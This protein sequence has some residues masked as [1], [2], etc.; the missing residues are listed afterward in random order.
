M[1]FEHTPPRRVRTRLYLVVNNYDMGKLSPHLHSLKVGSSVNIR[2]PVGR[3]K[4]EKNA[5]RRIGL[6]A[7]GSG[8]TPCLQLIRCLLQGPDMQDDHT[9]LVLLFQ[10]R[11]EEDILLREELDAL[12][13]SHSS[14]LQVVYFL[15][16]AQSHDFGA[17]HTKH[18]EKR[19]YINQA[20]VQSMLAPE[21]CQLVCICGPS[22]FN[23]S[24][25][26]LLLEAGHDEQKSIYVW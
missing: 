16:N 22:G 3:F 24:V 5:Y 18:A 14:R 2:G 8:L 12:Q 1:W 6:V 20:A 21:H 11:T 23:N 13:A 19:G 17:P 10:N 25:K 26:Q 7:G 15:S 9:S 4:Y